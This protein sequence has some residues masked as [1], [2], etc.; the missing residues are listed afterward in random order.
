MV[1]RTYSIACSSYRAAFSQRLNK[2]GN[3]KQIIGIAVVPN[4]FITGE[5]SGIVRAT[6]NTL[7][8]MQV[9]IITRLKQ[10][11]EDREH[12][13]R[14]D[15]LKINSEFVSAFTHLPRMHIAVILQ[16]CCSI[17]VCWLL[18]AEKKD[19]KKDITLSIAKKTQRVKKV[20]NMR[21]LVVF[22]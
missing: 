2:H 5:K 18:S 9:R 10:N 17:A 7:A 4:K 22:L 21:D 1:G 13:C 3:I 15:V 16:I 20:C 12:F 11:S 19:S 14:L 6:N 8:I